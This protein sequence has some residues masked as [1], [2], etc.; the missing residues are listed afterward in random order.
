M[1]LQYITI[2]VLSELSRSQSDMIRCT[3]EFR[4]FT[5]CLEHNMNFEQLIDFV[6][7]ILWR[8]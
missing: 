6:L 1:V 3:T 2:P 4:S 5:I 8:F 7:L